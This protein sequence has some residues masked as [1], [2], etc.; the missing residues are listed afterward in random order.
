MICK[1]RAKRT[2]DND[3]TTEK[4]RIALLAKNVLSRIKK[5]LR[6]LVADIGGRRPQ[7]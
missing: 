3:M 6:V 4:I 2:N 5:Y 7:A 1:A